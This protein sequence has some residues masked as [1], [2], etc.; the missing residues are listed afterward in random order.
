MRWK[1][2]K[3]KP[4]F[5]RFGRTLDFIYDLLFDDFIHYIIIIAFYYLPYPIHSIWDI[6]LNKAHEYCSSQYVSWLKCEIKFQIN[7]C[8]CWWPLNNNYSRLPVVHW[9]QPT[10]LM[11]ILA[12]SVRGIANIRSNGQLITSYISSWISA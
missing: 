4:I 2:I 5:Y 10:N 1:S 3:E 11:E 6:A 8:S 12:T 7:K 9:S